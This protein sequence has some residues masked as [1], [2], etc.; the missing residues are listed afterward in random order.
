MPIILSRPHLTPVQKE[1]KLKRAWRL[2]LG[3]VLLWGWFCALLFWSLATWM[4]LQGGCA[5][6]S[7]LLLGGLITS[8]AGW[9]IGGAGVIHVVYKDREPAN[10]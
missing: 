8:V 1:H 9:I 7:I 4:T 6:I 2:Q 5:S 10:G 3:F